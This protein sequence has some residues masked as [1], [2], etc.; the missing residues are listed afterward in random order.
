MKNTNRMLALSG[1]IG[2]VLYAIADLFL[3]FGVDVSSDDLLAMCRR[4]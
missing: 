4:N 3:Y 2:A 1:I